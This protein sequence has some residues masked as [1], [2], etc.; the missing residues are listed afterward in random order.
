MKLYAYAEYMLGRKLKCEYLSGSTPG[1]YPEESPEEKKFIRGTDRIYSAYAKFYPRRGF[2]YPCRAGTR[3]VSH[4]DI[5][6]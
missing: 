3:E 2:L 1:G 4:E 5:T 6:I